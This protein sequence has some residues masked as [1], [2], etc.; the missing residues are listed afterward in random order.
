MTMTFDDQFR[1]QGV[2]IPNGG[3]THTPAPAPAA[4]TPPPS[5]S[6]SAATFNDVWRNM[7]IQP[8]VTFENMYKPIIPPAVSG[9]AAGTYNPNQTNLNANGTPYS[10]VDSMNDANG[11]LMY[12]PSQSAMWNMLNGRFR[13]PGQ[14]TG[15]LTANYGNNPFTQQLINNG[16]LNQNHSGVGYNP[17]APGGSS[18]GW[19]PNPSGPNAEFQR[20]T[21]YLQRKGYLKDQTA[22]SIY[23]NLGTVTQDQYLSL[24]RE[25]QQLADA[26]FGAAGYTPDWM[27]G[28]YSDRRL[29]I[30]DW[31][32]D[33]Y[34]TLPMYQPT[35]DPVVG[36]ALN[37]SGYNPRN[38]YGNLRG[39][40]TR[41]YMYENGWM[42]DGRPMGWMP[43]GNTGGQLSPLAGNF[44]GNAA[45][46]QLAQLLQMFQGR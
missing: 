19:T 28:M 37:A 22:G 12:D 5:G 17:A 26:M 46:Q 16:Q 6:G 18:Q 34:D 11:Q 15:Q 36:S 45:M 29:D 32:K 44:G 23:N 7:G 8:Q 13:Q 27:K 25:G 9:S 30:Y 4:T 20:L 35:T 1:R 42:P 2:N 33:E 24:D 40:N 39:P 43:D 41:D 21:P 14:E 38:P 3:S 10:M 31:N